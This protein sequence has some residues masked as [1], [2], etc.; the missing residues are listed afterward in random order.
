MGQDWYSCDICGEAVSDYHPEYKS[1]EC[2][3]V[4][5]DD[6]CAS[7]AGYINYSDEG[8]EMPIHP[9]HGWSIES[10]CKYCRGEDV[11][12]DTLLEFALSRLNLSRE[13][14]VEDYIKVNN[15]AK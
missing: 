9:K 7:D 4:F 12:D 3:K 1:C 2:G 5:C 13:E 8:L 11:N 15:K 14:L 6:E 10:S